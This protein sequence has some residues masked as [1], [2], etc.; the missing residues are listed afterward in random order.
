MFIFRVAANETDLLRIG[1]QPHRACD[2]QPAPDFTNAGGCPAG[3]GRPARR[4]RRL[5]GRTARQGVAGLK[6]QASREPWPIRCYTG[7]HERA[8]RSDP[9]DGCDR[10][11]G[12]RRVGRGVAERAAGSCD[13]AHRTYRS[14]P[15]R[16]RDPL[17]RPRPGDRR[18]RRSSQRPV[19]RR[20]VPHQGSFRRRTRGSGS[21]MATSRSR[22]R[23]SS[24][25]PTRHSSAATVRPGW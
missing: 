11:S 1:R 10:S 15:Q 16:G 3:V 2:R 17:V 12:A 13:R 7:C 8:C 5:R 6:H 14:G 23:T 21:A 18:K 25:T 20:A 24:P 22:R 4:A 19:P 9:L